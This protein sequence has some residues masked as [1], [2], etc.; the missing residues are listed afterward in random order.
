MTDPLALLAAF[1]LV[2]VGVAR[3]TRL[4]VHDPY[5]PVQ[6]LRLRWITWQA[7]RDWDAA[8]QR[9]RTGVLHGWG[10]LVECPFCASPYIAAV[11][12]GTGVWADVWSPDLSTLAG[13]WLLLAAWATVSYL[14]AMIVLRD[15]PP[16]EHDH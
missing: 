12:L 13:W 10:S 11:A 2:T 6:A 3:A 16:A 15:E 8:A 4:V 5:P 1:L 9:E 7:T 14:A